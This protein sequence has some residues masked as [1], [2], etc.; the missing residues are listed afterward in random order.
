MTDK[1]LLKFAAEFRS[2]I[3]DGAP[4][5]MMCAAVSWPLAGLLNFHG[6]KCECVESD[7]GEMNHVWIK[8]EDGRALDATADQFNYLFDYKHHPVYL[9]PPLNFHIPKPLNM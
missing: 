9:G 8:L 1:Q 4:S 2:G 6:I 5:H 7:L 3:L